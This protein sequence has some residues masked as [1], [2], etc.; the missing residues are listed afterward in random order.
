MT[1]IVA[2]VNKFR[3]AHTD[4]NS[5]DTADKVVE[6]A[7]K[8]D[9][10]AILLDKYSFKLIQQL[11]PKPVHVFTAFEF[12][13]YGKNLNSVSAAIR[14]GKVPVF[15][16]DRQLLET[17]DYYPRRTHHPVIRTMRWFLP[18]GAIERSRLLY[19]IIDPRFYSPSGTASRTA[20]QNILRHCGLWYSA[21]ADWDVKVTKGGPDVQRASLA[22]LS[23]YSP[24]VLAQPKGITTP[25]P[26]I[27]YGIRCPRSF[28]LRYYTN[29]A[30]TKWDP[31]ALFKTTKLFLSTLVRIWTGTFV[32]ESLFKYKCEI[33][34]FNQFCLERKDQH[35]QRVDC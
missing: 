17:I 5:L 18:P 7:E 15:L 3:F 23:W 16:V 22:L 11:Q 29:I 27:T 25:D 26:S 33:E 35:E 8:Y 9:N 30:T 14:G 24:K 12:E 19:E 10:V 34:S 20:L 32:P 31:T 21:F 4:N 6:I 28:F 13:K 2:P 1:L